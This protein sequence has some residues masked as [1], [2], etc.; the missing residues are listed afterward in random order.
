MY[1]QPVL[2]LFFT[3]IRLRENSG[4]SFFVVTSFMG[5]AIT[6]ALIA[7]STVIALFGTCL[8]AQKPCLYAA[9][10]PVPMRTK[11]SQHQRARARPRS[12]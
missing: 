10:P 3:L 9:A 12:V 8:P 7:A 5:V 11:P 4:F 6:I 2:H 1:A